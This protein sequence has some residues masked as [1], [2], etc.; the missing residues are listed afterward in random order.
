MLGGEEPEK[1]KAKIQLCRY[2]HRQEDTKFILEGLDLLHEVGARPSAIR[3]E[4]V[5]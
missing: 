2:V 1:K 4:G 5:W 3:R